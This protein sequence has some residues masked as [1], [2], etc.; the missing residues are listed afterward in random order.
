MDKFTELLCFRLGSAARKLQKY[1]N[2]RLA[3]YGITIAQSFIILSLMEKDDRNVKELAESL[4]IDS[5]AITGLVDRLEKESLVERRV[6]TSDRRAFR[7]HLTARGRGLGDSMLPAAIEFNESL[8]AGLT[9][10]E[11]ASLYKFFGMLED[12]EL[13]PGQPPAGLKKSFGSGGES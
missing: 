3:E 2:G 8:E 4:G 7:I 10:T 6:D 1:Y 9:R 11:L 12:L 5:S 13:P